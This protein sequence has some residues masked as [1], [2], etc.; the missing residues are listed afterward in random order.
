MTERGIGP[1]FA[2]LAAIVGTLV[3]TLLPVSSASAGQKTL[4][5]AGQPTIS[6]PQTRT[7]PNLF[8]VHGN[9]ITFSRRGTKLIAKKDALAQLGFICN[10]LPTLAK[11]SCKATLWGQKKLIVLHAKRFHAQGNC[12]AISQPGSWPLGLR[13][14]SWNC[15]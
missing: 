15:R 8:E 11:Y 14:G 7:Q 6:V 2:A 1:I 4:S 13:K 3:L 5:V 12:V 9:V 10:A